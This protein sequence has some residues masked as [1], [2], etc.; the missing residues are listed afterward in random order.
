MILRRRFDLDHQVFAV[1]RV[2]PE[3]EPPYVATVRAVLGCRITGQV[4]AGDSAEWLLVACTAAERGILQ[5]LGFEFDLAHD[6]AE[7]MG[8]QLN[9]G[10]QRM[11]AGRS[12]EEVIG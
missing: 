12:V 1:L 2:L 6:Y 5:R 3:P 9:T 10:A 4:L 7:E 8:I 11:G